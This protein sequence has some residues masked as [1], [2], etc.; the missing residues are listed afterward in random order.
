MT[1]ETDQSTT[2]AAAGGTADAPPP[3]PPGATEPPSPQ[4]AAG[5]ITARHVVTVILALLPGLGHL[6]N[7]L[8]MR[9]IKFFLAALAAVYLATEVGLA[10]MAVAFVW[11]F[12]MI[13]AY[14]QA[15]LI[16]D[17]HVP[18][19]GVHDEATVAPAGRSGLLWG[20]GFF[21]VGFLLL[22]DH[23]FGYDMDRVWEFWPVGLLAIGA[24]L[25]I[26][27]WLQWR[28]KQAEG[29]DDTGAGTGMMAG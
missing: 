28:R 14:R 20:V 29:Q 12:N 1:T 16:E 15:T 9:G 13:D 18:D 8:Y 17:G 6:Y 22:L 26:G 21:V 11:L 4:P 10:G 27:A 7:G 19:L 24:W 23:T 3:P 5:Q 2:G 25:M